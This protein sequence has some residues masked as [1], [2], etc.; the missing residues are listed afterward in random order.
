[1]TNRELEATEVVIE[2]QPHLDPA[3]VIDALPPQDYKSNYQPDYSGNTDALLDAINEL[4]ATKAVTTPRQVDELQQALTQLARG[5]IDNPII[6]TGRCAEP[7][8]LATPIE[9]LAAESITVSDVVIAALGT[10]RVINIRRERG[11]NTKP[12]SN[13]VEE[14]PDGRIVP[15]YM[16]DAVNTHDTEHRTPDPSRM[17]AAAVQARDLEA[18]LT[19]VTGRHIPAAHEALLLPYEHS[20]IRIDPET[21]RKYL[22]SADVPWIGKRTN[23]PAGEHVTLLA[24]VT[25]PIGIKVGAE[26][27]PEHIGAL[28][29]LLNPDGVPGKI[30]FM[31]R[32]G[33][34]NP[35]KLDAVVSAIKHYAPESLLMYDIHGVTRTAPNGSK[36]RYTGDIIEDIKLTATACRK[37]GLKLHGLHL[38]TIADNDRLECVDQPD[39]LPLHP[40][41]VDPQLNPR[42]TEHILRETAQYLL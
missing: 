40:G 31:L 1:M 41:G 35:D 20:F 26:S 18:K 9:T 2:E 4:H 24:E 27:T 12:R 38:E 39:Q 36:I 25:N 32:M 37:A 11:Q 6:I 7:V 8:A 17:V 42:Q 33:L 19:E 3:G 22:L 10:G 5:E 15:P 34:N 16:G 14:L 28:R 21:G 30:I 23:D 29:E 13:H